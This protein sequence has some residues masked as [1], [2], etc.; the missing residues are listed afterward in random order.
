M[1]DST[2]ASET[3]V[4]LIDR[5]RDFCLNGALPVT[6]ADTAIITSNEVYKTASVGLVVSSLDWHPHD[7]ASFASSNNA[8]LF[9]TKIIPTPDGVPVNYGPN[10]GATTV[11]QVMWPDHC[12][13]ESFGAMYHRDVVF[14]RAEEMTHMEVKKGTQKGIDPYSA[15]GDEFFGQFEQTQL[16]T[17]LQ[18][19]KIKKVL[20]MGLALDYCVTF[21]ALD[22]RRLGYI[23]CIY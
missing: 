12:V 23:T 4:L 11:S 13:Q 20:I 18:T 15:F 5:Q 2:I 16:N 6:D 9:S 14:T 3:A 17:I 10:K 22:S 1:S 8:D 21:T 19:H 7:H